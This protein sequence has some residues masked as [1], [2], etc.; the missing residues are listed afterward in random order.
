ML[1]GWLFPPSTH[2]T[3]LF[4]S[5]SRAYALS[6]WG[7]D[8]T[9]F[10]ALL[11]FVLVWK[12]LSITIQV[13]A[14]NLTSDWLLVASGGVGCLGLTLIAAA[15]AL[16]LT[17]WACERVRSWLLKDMFEEIR[18]TLAFRVRQPGGLVYAGCDHKHALVAAAEAGRLGDIIAASRVGHDAPQ[19]QAE[20][21]RFAQRARQEIAEWDPKVSPLKQGETRRIFVQLG[22]GGLII[23]R[24]HGDTF[25]FGCALDARAMEDGSAVREMDELGAAIKTILKRH[26]AL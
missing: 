18:Q 25:L 4:R 17:D 13:E 22:K 1:T 23:D 16:L 12:G 6:L 10:G 14:L 24:V 11:T 15:C 19:Q 2:L 9:M 8:L 20:Y 21:T 26:G 3:N 7:L 5:C